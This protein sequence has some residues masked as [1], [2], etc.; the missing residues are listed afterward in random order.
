MGFTLHDIT[1]HTLLVTMYYR[2]LN[3][4]SHCV[5]VITLDAVLLTGCDRLPL[6]TDRNSLWG[7]GRSTVGG[8][9]GMHF[10]LLHA[11]YVLSPTIACYSVT[12]GSRVRVEIIKLNTFIN[13]KLI[14]MICVFKI[15]I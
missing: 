8:R 12:F 2:P 1:S 14:Q 7:G 3:T 6:Y 9:W 11:T 5:K 4:I 13:I 15:H 10:I